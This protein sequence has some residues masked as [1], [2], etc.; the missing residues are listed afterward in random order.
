MSN[1]LKNNI[2]ASASEI[3]WGSRS[4]QEMADRKFQEK[5]KIEA[6]KKEHSIFGSAM[7]GMVSSAE[8]S[9][10]GNM[11]SNSNRVLPTIPTSQQSDD[12]EYE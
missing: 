1:E 5:E 4:E 12:M 8:K 6:K 10:S 2:Y 7:K 9:I 3:A 11:K